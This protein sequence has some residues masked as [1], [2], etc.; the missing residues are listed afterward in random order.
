MSVALSYITKR[1]FL[2]QKL[3]LTAPWGT[4]NYYYHERMAVGQCV[5]TTSNRNFPFISVLLQLTIINSEYNAH[6]FLFFA[7]S[8]Q[9]VCPLRFIDTIRIFS[10]DE[11]KVQNAQYFCLLE[12]SRYHGDGIFWVVSLVLTTISTELVN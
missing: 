11:N 7:F 12:Y 8:A 1:R 4:V 9:I 5:P 10:W 2:K 6:V 3:S